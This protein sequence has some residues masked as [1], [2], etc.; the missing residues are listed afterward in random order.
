V[1]IIQ[2]WELE[3]VRGGWN[4]LYYTVGCML[5]VSRALISNIL[6]LFCIYEVYSAIHFTKRFQ[7]V[8]MRSQTLR[9]EKKNPI[10]HCGVSTF[11]CSLSTT[12]IKHMALFDQRSIFNAIHKFF[13]GL[14]QISNDFKVFLYSM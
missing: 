1:I 7:C 13:I 12:K 9:F 6:D 11:L 3:G 4:I 10:T 14:N 5:R 2:S 8:V